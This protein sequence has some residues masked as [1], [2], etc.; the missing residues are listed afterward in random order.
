MVDSA[1]G[2]ELLPGGEAA[3]AREMASGPGA[4]GRGGKRMNRLKKWVWD[5]RASTRMAYGLQ[6]A[7]RAF[8]SALSLVW[9]P[10]MI[11]AMGP[12]LY[13]INYS[14]QRLITLGG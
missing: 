2:R 11:G 6:L 9:I 12:E 8:T 13:G 10:L 4:P 3:V 14:F 7:S 1:T 5:H